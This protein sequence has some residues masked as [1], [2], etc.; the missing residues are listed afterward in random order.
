M[1]S[2]IVNPAN[3][4]SPTNPNNLNPGNKTAELTTTLD[5]ATQA[6]IA[7]ATLTAAVILS[8]IHIASKK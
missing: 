8:A 5:P 7:A 1:P 3:P 2:W 4:A 6:S